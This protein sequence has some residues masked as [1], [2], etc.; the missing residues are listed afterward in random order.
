MA[1]LFKQ[2]DSKRWWIGF[3]VDGNLHRK[4]TGYTSKAKAQEVLQEYKTLESLRGSRKLLDQFVGILTGEKKVCPSAAGYIDSWYEGKRAEVR[5]STHKTYRLPVSELKEFLAGRGIETLEDITPRA[6][7]DYLSSCAERVGRSAVHRRRQLIRQVLSLAKRE[8]VISEDPSEGLKL[9]GRKS[10]TKK[11]RRPFSTDELNLILEHCDPFWRFMVI[12][13]FTTGLRMGDLISLTGKGI[14]VRGMVA[15]C[16]TI[17]TGATVTIPISKQFTD[18]FKD[19]ISGQGAIFTVQLELYIEKGAWPFSDRFAK[20]LRFAGLTEKPRR[21]VRDGK[22]GSR[23]RVVNEISFHSLRHTFISFLQS[24]GV[25]ESITSGMVGHSTV[26]MTRAYTTI[27]TET[28][29]RAVGNLPEVG[30]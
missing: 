1:W 8:R 3:R 29:R 25:A 27:P 24:A 22:G 19:Q 30:R 13:G 21:G 17:K 10:E 12:G 26:E 2:T 20:I 9:P 4:S 23:R 16:T 28:L 15:H 18:T 5:A 11:T 7:A 14:D 6:L